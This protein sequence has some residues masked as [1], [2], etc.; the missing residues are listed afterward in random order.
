MF[1][2]N[3]PDRV[4]RIELP[5]QLLRINKTYITSS[6]DLFVLTEGPEHYYVYRVNLDTFEDKDTK[7]GRGRILTVQ[8]VMYYAKTEVEDAPILDFHVRGG[9]SEKGKI[10]V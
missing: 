10:E 1:N 2:V 6:Y 5:R 9:S 7:D 4:H 8:D 3:E